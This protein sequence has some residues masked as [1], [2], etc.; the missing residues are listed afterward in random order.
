MATKPEGSKT[1]QTQ[2]IL[3]ADIWMDVGSDNLPFSASTA[4]PQFCST[5][6]FNTCYT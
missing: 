2:V 1:S 5:T 4:P 6:R 3:P